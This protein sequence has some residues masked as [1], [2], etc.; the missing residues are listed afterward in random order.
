MAYKLPRFDLSIPVVDDTNHGTLTFHQWWDR[1]MNSI[2]KAL[3]GLGENIEAI[4]A[5]LEA[6]G[7]AISAAESA[8]AAAEAAQ[9]A[10]QSGSSVSKLS[11]SGVTGMTFSATDAG[12]NATITISSHTRVYSDGVQVSVSGGSVTGLSYST[13]YYVYYDDPEFDGG[14]VSYV[15]TTVQADSA[16]TGNRHFVGTVVTPAAAGAPQDGQ[17]PPVPGH[18]YYEV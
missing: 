16:Q 13:R 3:S 12:T 11:G 18:G 6:A 9:A 17:T 10:A 4:E 7:I 2:E 1:A 5:A 14:G 15:A 8:Q